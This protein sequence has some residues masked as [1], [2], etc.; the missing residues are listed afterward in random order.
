LQDLAS[1]L[2]KSV[3]EK[4]ICYALQIPHFFVALRVRIIQLSLCFHQFGVDT[5]TLDI[6]VALGLPLEQ[7]E[8]QA[9]AS[10]NELVRLQA[11]AVFGVADTIVFFASLVL[12]KILR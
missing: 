4:V 9:L 2:H 5:L 7:V 1:S 3:N 12:P 8:Q 10:F 6:S 11:Q